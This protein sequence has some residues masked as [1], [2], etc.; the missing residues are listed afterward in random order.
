M[1]VCGNLS[2]R[3]RERERQR[4]RERKTVLNRQKRFLAIYYLQKWCSEA[5]VSHKV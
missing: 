2:D 5:A 1:W 4:E 3:K